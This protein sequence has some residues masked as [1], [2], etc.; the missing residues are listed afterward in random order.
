MAR[1]W[2]DRDGFSVNSILF[3]FISF[4]SNGLEIARYNKRKEDNIYDK[5]TNSGSFN[6]PVGFYSFWLVYCVFNGLLR[7][8]YSFID[9]FHD[10]EFFYTIKDPRTILH[11]FS[12]CMLQSVVR[13]VF[14]IRNSKH[15]KKFHWSVSLCV[16]FI[17]Y[18]KRKRRQSRNYVNGFGI[19]TEN[20][21]KPI[22]KSPSAHWTVIGFGRFEP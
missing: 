17:E 9:H 8:S 3:H 11:S 2:S 15:F 4:S 5:V 16:R 1:I 20:G 18:L 21:I 13:F 10:W 14:V 12:V 7:D 19:Q 22:K 6:F